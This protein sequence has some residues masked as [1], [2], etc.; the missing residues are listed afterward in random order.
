MKPSGTSASVI[1]V[2]F[3][4]F[5]GGGGTEERVAHGRD[6]VYMGAPKKAAR[7]TGATATRLGET[8]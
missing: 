1:V 8:S 3:G 7:L 2:W 4:V 5:S 6:G